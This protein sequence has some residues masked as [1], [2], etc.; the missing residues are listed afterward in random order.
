MSAAAAAVPLAKKSQNQD[1][2]EEAGSWGERHQFLVTKTLFRGRTRFQDV[3]IIET[4]EYDKMLVID[5]APQSAEYDEYVYHE[6]LV[7]P[8]MAMHPNPRRVLVIG[9]GEGATIREALRHTTVERVV[10]IDIDEELVGLCRRLMPEWHRG[11]FDDPRLDL[12]H[13]DGLAYMRDSTDQYDVVIVDVCDEGDDNAAAPIYSAK[14]YASVKARL[15][16]GGIAVIQA[17]ELTVGETDGH[18]AI[19]RKLNPLFRRVQ[20]YAAFVPSFW[21]D[22]S[23]I[24]AGDD[25]PAALP[26]PEALDRVLAER[27]IADA[28]RFYDGETHRRLLSLPKDLRTAIGQR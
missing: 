19:R 23:F 3:A 15:A 25:L 4:A 27:G 11:A 13:C 26:A 12:R 22:W 18:A 2:F 28:L 7:H 20:S 16:P 9:G 17:M 5:G 6:S 14:F 10:M 8:A 21:C 24:M 1:W